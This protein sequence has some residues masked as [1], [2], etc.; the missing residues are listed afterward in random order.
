MKS[1]KTHSSIGLARMAASFSGSCLFPPS[2]GQSL[3]STTSSSTSAFVARTPPVPSPT[4]VSS[5]FF[6]GDLPLPLPSPSSFAPALSPAPSPPSARGRSGSRGM[7]TWWLHPGK[8]CPAS[9]RNALPTPSPP[10]KRSGLRGSARAAASPPAPAAL[11]RGLAGAAC[12][13]TAPTPPRCMLPI[14]DITAAANQALALFQAA[15]G[16]GPPR[17]GEARLQRL[18]CCRLPVW[19]NG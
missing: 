14:A 12:S 18:D 4:P 16:R 17:A 5:T 13:L 7:A 19:E 6:L 10:T 3:V 9:P 1:S 11:A 8:R 2:C 15:D